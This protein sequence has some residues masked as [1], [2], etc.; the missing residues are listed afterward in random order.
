M[1]QRG[2]SGS[3]KEVEKLGLDMKITG[4]EFEYDGSKILIFF[5]APERVDFRELIKALVPILHHIAGI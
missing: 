5:T 3:K 1:Q 4:A 2:K